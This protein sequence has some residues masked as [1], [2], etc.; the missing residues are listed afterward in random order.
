[1]Q[2]HSGDTSVDPTQVFAYQCSEAL[3]APYPEL[4]ESPGF[5]FR[6]KTHFLGMLNNDTTPLSKHEAGVTLVHNDIRVIDSVCKQLSYY[7]LPVKVI[8][9]CPTHWTPPS[10]ITFIGRVDNLSEHVKTEVVICGGGNNTVCELLSRKKKLVIIPE[11]KPYQEQLTKARRLDNMNA[12]VLLS[13]A[14]L[15]EEKS[16]S[17]A[18]EKTRG[19]CDRTLDTMYQ[20]SV[21]LDWSAEFEKIVKDHLLCPSQ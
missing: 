17:R 14:V 4:C 11:E 9:S 5:A 12:A 7:D 15:D 10:H 3:Y 2:R 21:N 16:V 20:D 19:L 6:Q 13:P 18:I 1:M 8:S